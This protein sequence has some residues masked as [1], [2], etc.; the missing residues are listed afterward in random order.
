M[1][2]QEQKTILLVEDDIGTTL[3]ETQLLKSFGYDV[4]AAK[5]GEEAVNVAMGNNKVALILMDINL[6]SGIDGTEA[7]RQILGKR[8]LPIVFLSSHTEKEYVERVKAITRYGYVIKNSDK[9]VLQSSIEMAFHLFE[10]HEAMRESENLLNEV[11]G[12][13]LVGGWELDVK[14]NDVRWTKETYRIHD[15]SEDEKFDLSE[16]I[17][18]YDM[19]GRS[20]LETALQRCMEKGEPFDLEL[21][22]TSAK[23]RHLWTRAMG[24][25]TNVAGKVVKLT[26]TFMDIT[27][28][29]Q[30]EKVLRLT[31]YSID[32]IADSIFWIDKSARFIFVNNAACKNLGYSKEE[33]LA[34]TIFDV[35]PVFPKE[36]WQEHW[37]KIAKLGSFSIETI[38]KTKDGREISVEVTTNFVEY[39]GQQ[40]NCAVA[41]DI[42]ARKQAEKAL[43]KA[44]A[45][46]ED[47]VKV[48]ERTKELQ[49]RINELERFHKATVEREF[50]MK[51]LRDEIERL[52]SA[53]EVK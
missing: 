35:D 43:A 6:G 23:G 30:V 15:L 37:Q 4:V 36:K 8:Q 51:E 42:T 2:N 34:M 32:N 10:A 50:R 12:M 38:H 20:T 3:I 21:P 26:G 9:F 16:A 19:P 41:R 48:S 13:V 22:F 25:A 24:R 1:K 45:G 17:L 33:F 7:A 18:F 53:K 29:K 52:K 28:R 14:T 49:V 46:L 40:L 47:K 27:E 5:S 31:Q 11:G 44:Y 39:G